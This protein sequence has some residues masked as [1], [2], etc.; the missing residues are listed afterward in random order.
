MKTYYTLT[1]QTDCRRFFREH[2]APG[3]DPR[4]RAA[5][6]TSFNDWT[7]SLHKNHEISRA[8]Y[9]RWTRN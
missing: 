1:N 2:I 5:L 8:A 3:I 7:D 4:D 6:D 9:N